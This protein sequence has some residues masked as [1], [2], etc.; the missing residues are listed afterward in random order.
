MNNKIDSCKTDDRNSKKK[1]NLDISRTYQRYIFKSK[2]SNKSN[3]LFVSRYMNSL[4]LFKSFDKIFLNSDLFLKVMI[5][6]FY[7]IFYLVLKLLFDIN[8]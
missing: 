6:L 5:L 8:L 4:K 1:L 7:C 3:N 2:K